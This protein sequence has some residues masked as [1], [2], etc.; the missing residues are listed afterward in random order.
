MKH[1]YI[2][3]TERLI[4]EGFVQYDVM[5]QQAYMARRVPTQM[6]RPPSATKVRDNS[7]GESSF[8]TM[9]NVSDMDNQGKCPEGAWAYFF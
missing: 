1:E 8:D 2:L 6:K 7:V 9:S 5:N 3:F 4:P